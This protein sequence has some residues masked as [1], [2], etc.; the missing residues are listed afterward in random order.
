MMLPLFLCG[1]W[2][3]ERSRRW[4]PGFR[5]AKSEVTVR[6]PGVCRGARRQVWH[7]RKVCGSP[8]RR[9]CGSGTES[10]DAKASAGRR[11]GRRGLLTRMEQAPW[12]AH[13]SGRGGGQ[14]VADSGRGPWSTAGEELTGSE[15]GVWKQMVPI[16]PSGEAAAQGLNQTAQRG[17]TQ[18]ATPGS[19]KPQNFA[20]ICYTARGD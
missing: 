14:P 16:K 15:G 17:P 1:R 7:T 9:A 19:L 5:A 11:G 3:M 20:V 18:T 4:R 13:P 12:S 2:W 6:R 8:T 10:Q